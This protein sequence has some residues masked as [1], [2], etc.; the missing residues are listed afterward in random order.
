MTEELHPTLAELCALNSMPMMELRHVPAVGL[1]VPLSTARN[2]QLFEDINTIKRYDCHDSRP[3][4][5]ARPQGLMA[6][7]RSDISVDRWQRLY[8][9]PLDR[10][11]E[12]KG[13][14]SNGSD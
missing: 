7:K 2:V 8:R 11:D 1:G 5:R 13:G 9:V 12:E 10:A 14:A 6:K 3:C 4:Y